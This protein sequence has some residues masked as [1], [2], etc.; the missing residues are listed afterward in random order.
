MGERRLDEID[1]HKNRQPKPVGI[2]PV[3]E[4]KARQHQGTRQNA[5]RIFNIH[6]RYMSIFSYIDF[7]NTSL[8][9]NRVLGEIF[10]RLP[11]LVCESRG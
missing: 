8:N 6:T 3:S 2:N 1:S 7:A 4:N 10:N 9:E 5:N 11:R